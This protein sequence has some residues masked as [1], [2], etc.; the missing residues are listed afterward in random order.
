MSFNTENSPSSTSIDL[1]SVRFSLFLS[2]ADIKRGNSTFFKVNI[3]NAALKMGDDRDL[4]KIYWFFVIY[5]SITT[6][7]YLQT[8]FLCTMMMIV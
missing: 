8:Y 7:I 3:W 4:N 6:I 5:Y 2:A 1:I